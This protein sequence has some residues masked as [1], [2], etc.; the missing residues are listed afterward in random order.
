M[1]SSGIGL[2]TDGCINREHVNGSHYLDRESA[3]LAKQ[4]GI[5]ARTVIGKRKVRIN[6]EVRPFL[7]GSLA[8]DA[9]QEYLEV[10][11]R[12]DSSS[13]KAYRLPRS[14]LPEG[15]APELTEAYRRLMRAARADPEALRGEVLTEDQASRLRQALKSDIVIVTMF[16]GDSVSLGTYLSESLM[17]TLIFCPQCFSSENRNT[18][19]ASLIDLRSRKV[20]RTDHTGFQSGDIDTLTGENDAANPE[21]F[22]G[23]EWFRELTYYFFFDPE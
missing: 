2:I 20:L 18:A 14:E 15:T 10:A 19:L 1:R 6:T 11:P 7:C 21:N 3:L 17:K 16:W 12:L 4:L 23:T 5:V 9:P 22:S 8:L 13:S